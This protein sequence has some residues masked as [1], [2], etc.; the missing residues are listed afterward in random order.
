MSDTKNSGKG[1]VIQSGIIVLI[2]ISIGVSGYMI[3][4][5]LT[6]Q[7][8]SNKRIDELNKKQDDFVNRW[9]H[10]VK[11]SNNINNGTQ[12]KIE[13][14]VEN[15]LGN[16]SAHRHVTNESNDIIKTLLNKTLNTESYSKLADKRTEKI[17]DAIHATQNQSSQNGKAI[18]QIARALNVTISDHNTDQDKLKELLSEILNKTQ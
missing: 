1:L 15:V 10:R 11:I 5:A 16:L 12:L 13:R 9:E 17:I 2:L 3:N 6:I 7:I 14:S 4:Q 18:N 8:E